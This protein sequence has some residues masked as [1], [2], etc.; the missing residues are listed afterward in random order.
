M[1]ATTFVVQGAGAM[2]DPEGTIVL[3]RYL[4]RELP[5]GDRV[6]APEMPRAE[7]DPRYEPWRDAIRDQ[8]AQIEGPTHVV[9]HSFGGSV[10]LRMI[11]EA[12]I[13]PKIRSLHL[14]AMPW[15]GPDG[16]EWE[17]LALPDEVGTSLPDTGI[18]LY[19]SVDDPHV[20]IAHLGHYADAIPQAVVRRI[21]G[22]EHSFRD[23][24]AELVEDILAAGQPPRPTADR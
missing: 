11:A 7:D 15:W 8:L 17:E 16:W 6:L 1:T 2:H 13:D 5:A 4:E 10:V 18:Y 14:I 19:H 3:V 12:G 23:G 24:L 20:P 22:A 9:G 21:P